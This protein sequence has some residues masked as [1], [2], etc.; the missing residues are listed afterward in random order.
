MRKT[1]F[2]VVTFFLVTP[3][4][5]LASKPFEI[6]LWN[7]AIPG[8]SSTMKETIVDRPITDGSDAKQDRHIRGVTKPTMTVY[9]PENPNPK[10][11]AVVILPGGGFSILAIDKEGHDVAR[12]LNELGVVGIVVKYRLPDTNAKVYVRNSS[13]PDVQRAI[14]MTRSNSDKWKID[15]NRI[16]VVG[17][18]AGGYLTAAIGTM[19]DKGDPNASDLIERESCRPDFI[20]PIYPLVSLGSL[21]D[22]RTEFL[23][24]MLGPSPS[25]ELR[26]KYSPEQQ[27]D[28]KTPPTFLVHAND[29]RLNSEHSVT[30]YLALKRA[31][32]PVELHVFS[33][34]G[35]GYGI[36]QRGLPIS[37]WPKRWLDWMQNEGFTSQQQSK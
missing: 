4:T 3:S 12:W 24:R 19:Y 9:L 6:P 28:D 1:I 2:V 37:N 14:R 18:S 36:R 15:P 10:R 16:G 11:T 25:D 13:I 30:F 32:V 20:A 21:A 7:D 26:H 22:S 8:P 35:H 5:M 17:F 23:I 29:D 33:R 31:G 34:G 27:V